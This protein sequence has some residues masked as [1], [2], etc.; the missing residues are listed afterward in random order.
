MKRRVLFAFLPSQA[1][2][3]LLHLGAPVTAQGSPN[4]SL[5]PCEHSPGP[6]HLFRWACDELRG[7]LVIFG[8]LS[9]SDGGT[10][11]TWVHDGVDWILKNPVHRPGPRYDASLAWDPIRARVLL[12]GGEN[13]AETWEWDGTDWLQQTP[14]NSP[15]PRNFASLA[16]DPVRQR[17]VL[18]GGFFAPGQRN[19]TWEWDGTNWVERHPVQQPPPGNFGLEWEQLVWD[20]SRQRGVLVRFTG[21]YRI[22]TVFEWDGTNWAD[23]TP[24]QVPPP[25]MRSSLAFDPTLGRV[26]LYGGEFNDLWAWDGTAWTLLQPGGQDPHGVNGHEITWHPGWRSVVRYGGWYHEGGFVELDTLWMLSTLNHPPQA[27]TFGTAC[28]S[29]AGLPLLVPLQSPWIG[30][31]AHLGLSGVPASQPWILALGLSD[32]NYWHL[33]LP[34]E[35]SSFGMPNCWMHS[36]IVDAH[37]MSTGGGSS[38]WSMAIPFVPALAGLRVLQQGYVHDPLHNQRG[39]V[40]TNAVSLVLGSTL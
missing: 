24:A 32:T 12:F 20:S 9:S 18:F 31:T 6:F 25:R 26:L 23:R 13:S 33:M 17:M 38:R 19:D 8:G 37:A 16:H 3:I 1:L 10:Q 29:S 21:G 7:Q 40:T 39:F 2:L 34:A 36:S 28:A 30:G 27:T 22:C 14:A 4:W 11:D 35:L 5:V 15:P